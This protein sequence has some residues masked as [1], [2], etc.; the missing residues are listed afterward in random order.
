MAKLGLSEQF[1]RAVQAI[2]A[3]AAGT[4]RRDGA[5]LDARIAPLVRVAEQLRGLPRADFKARLKA[6]FEG[7]ATMASKPVAHPSKR[8]RQGRRRI[9][10]RVRKKAI[11]PRDTTRLRRTSRWRMPPGLIDF[12]K[13]TFGAEET[14]RTTG[15]AG[16]IHCE[17]RVGNS[18]LMVGGGS[19]EKPLP[20]GGQPD[21]SAGVRRGLRGDVRSGAGGGGDVGAEPSDQPYGERLAGVKDASGNHLVHCV[22]LLS[23]GETAYDPEWVQSGASVLA[24]GESEL[25]R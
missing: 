10:R 12:L 16:G 7:S 17:L 6:E 8:R 13:Q 11:F 22:S 2:L 21:D 20:R 25:R 24:S 9:R 23:G 15:G 1:D 5:G 19:A 3:P 4:R 18:M 14:F